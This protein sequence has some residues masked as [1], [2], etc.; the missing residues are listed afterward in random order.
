MSAATLISAITTMLAASLL[1]PH[2]A[3]TQLLRTFPGLD[4]LPEDD[5]TWVW[6]DRR[7][8]AERIAPDVTVSGRAAEFQCVLTARVLVSSHVSEVEARRIE[9]E[10]ADSARFIRAAADAMN[11]LDQ[12]RDLDWGRLD[13]ERLTRRNAGSADDPSLDR[14]RRRTRPQR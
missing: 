7:R 4:D 11:F 5:F 10:V 9:T 12:S 6:G 1:V 2:A 14:D 8:A 3:Y 13:C